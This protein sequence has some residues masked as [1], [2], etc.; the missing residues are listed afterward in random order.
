MPSYEK[1]KNSGLWS[2]RFRETDEKGET[3]QKRLSGYKSKK[4]AQYAYEDYIKSE[5]ER[6]AAKKAEEEAKKRLPDE[7]T[8]LQLYHLFIDFKRTRV[9]NS[10]LYDM[11]KKI[12]DK[13]LPTFAEMKVKEIAPS[14]VLKWM[15]RLSGYSYC[16]RKNLFSFLAAICSFGEKYYTIPNVTKNVDRP[17]NTERKREMEIWTPEEF[18]AAIS[19]EEDPVFIAFFTTLYTLG[20]RRGEALAITWNDINFAKNTIKIDKNITFKTT[21]KQNGQSYEVTTPKNKGS[22]RIVA[23]PPFLLDILKG[24]KP[25]KIT[26]E[27]PFVFGGESPLSATNIERHLTNCAVAAGIKRI[28]VHDLRHSCASY[29]IHSGVSIVAVSRQLGHTDVEQTLNTYSHLLP[30][31]RSQIINN[32]QALGDKITR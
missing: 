24:I 28:R 9:K 25:A 21:N 16:Y 8:F 6:E 19:T 30:D 18:S 10:T 15:N 14:D 2:C 20:C 3:H 17:R 29:L 5:E 22:V 11:E 4:D 7:M 32:L 26:P 31:D 23:A 12:T 27:K 1:N 13:I